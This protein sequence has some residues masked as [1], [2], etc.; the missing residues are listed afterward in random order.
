MNNQKNTLWNNGWIDLWLRLFLGG[1]FIYASY[2]KILDPAAF[3]KN[4]YSYYLFPAAS[5]N[6]IAIVQRIH[7]VLGR[8]L[9]IAQ[10]FVLALLE[11]TLAD[12]RETV[13]LERLPGQPAP[14]GPHSLSRKRK[15]LMPTPPSPVKSPNRTGNG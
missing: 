10:Q 3:A 9:R 14:H 2:H 5:I 13:E 11:R 15:S 7:Q 4:I 8:P 1:L 6:L 12:G